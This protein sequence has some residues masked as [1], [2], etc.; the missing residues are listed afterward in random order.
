MFC[1]ISNDAGKVFCFFF[2]ALVPNLIDKHNFW[3]FFPHFFPLSFNQSHSNW[4]Q[5][6]VE[7]QLRLCVKINQKPGQALLVAKV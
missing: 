4:Y 2:G 1:K 7:A 6:R 5:K 3:Q